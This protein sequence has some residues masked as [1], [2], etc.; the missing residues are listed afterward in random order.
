MERFSPSLLEECISVPI[1]A[2]CWAYAL[3]SSHICVLKVMGGASCISRN[4][5]CFSFPASSSSVNVETAKAEISLHS[6]K[7]GKINDLTY[8]EPR[9]AKVEQGFHYDT[10]SSISICITVKRTSTIQS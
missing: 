1:C 9:K 5:L 3:A 2:S 7:M 10:N 8:L 6:F 4:A